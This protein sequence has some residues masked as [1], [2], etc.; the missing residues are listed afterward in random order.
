MTWIEAIKEN[1]ITIPDGFYLCLLENGDMTVLEMTKDKDGYGV[2]EPAIPY[3][4][5]W[6]T[7]NELSRV[8][9]IRP[10]PAPPND[11]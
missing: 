8:T 2:Y 3:D 7:F 11:Q 4:T 1:I 6:V 10:L 5:D 9:H